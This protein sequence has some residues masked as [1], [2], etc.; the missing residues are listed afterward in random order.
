VQP[1]LGGTLSYSVP[2]DFIFIMTTP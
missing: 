2:T 1:I